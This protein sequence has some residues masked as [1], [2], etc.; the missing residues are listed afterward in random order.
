LGQFFSFRGAEELSHIEEHSG[1]EKDGENLADDS[2]KKLVWPEKKK[3]IL[4][5]KSVFLFPEPPRSHTPLIRT[6]KL[7]Q[8]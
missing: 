6:I 8:K 1:D 2:I 3:L 5:K 7:A 4:K